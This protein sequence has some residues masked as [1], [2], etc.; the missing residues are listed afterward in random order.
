[1]IVLL[2]VFASCICLCVQAQ[3][4]YG[5]ISGDVRAEGYENEYINAA[6]VQLFVGKDTLVTKDAVRPPVQRLLL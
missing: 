3:T 4:K 6:N 1:M 2:T 5:N